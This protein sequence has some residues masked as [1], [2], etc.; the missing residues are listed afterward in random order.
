MPSNTFN[1]KSIIPEIESATEAQQAEA[2]GFT[3]FLKAAAKIPGVQVL[4][5]AADL[6]TPER[7]TRNDLNL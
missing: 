4:S 1:T 6:F 7:A 2:E 5:M 3:S